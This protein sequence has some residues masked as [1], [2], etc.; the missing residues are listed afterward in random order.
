MISKRHVLTAGHCTHGMLA[1][2]LDVIVGQHIRYPSDGKVYKTKKV[3][4]H[5]RYKEF[6][7][8]T[9]P[10]V[11]ESVD[12][13]FSILTLE[14]EVELSPNVFPVCLPT[15]RSSLSGNFLDGKMLTVS[16]WGKT[17]KESPSNELRSVKI[18]GIP[19]NECKKVLDP[20]EPNKIG[21]C[22]LC[23]GSLN[24][25]TYSGFCNGDS[26]GSAP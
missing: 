21:P 12:Y 17:E 10:S 2:Q 13:D 5:P 8:P 25:K 20:D 19:S 22:H 11:V 26:G 7:H 3:T 23:A 18:P 24:A 4:R 14:K 6:S 9:I 15:D 1:Y 16:G